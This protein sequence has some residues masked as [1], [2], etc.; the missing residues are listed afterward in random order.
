MKITREE[1][2]RATQEYLAKGGQI[3][4]LSPVDFILD[5][6]YGDD[7][8]LLPFQQEPGTVVPTS[9]LLPQDP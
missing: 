7:D 9:V 1:I 8:T 6:D 5:E 4:K 3:Q 2:E